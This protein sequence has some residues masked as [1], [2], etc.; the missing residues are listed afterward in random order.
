MEFIGGVLL[1]LLLVVVFGPERR[2]RHE[3]NMLEAFPKGQWTVYYSLENPDKWG[4]YRGGIMYSE[5]DTREEAQAK[6]D[7]LH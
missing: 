2:S 7:T 1:F 5:F 3:R 4:I 6:A